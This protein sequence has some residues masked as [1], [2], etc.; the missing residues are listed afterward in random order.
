MIYKRSLKQ[1]ISY[2]YDIDKFYFVSGMFCYLTK[3]AS[4]LSVFC[5][6]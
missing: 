3:V 5:F 2:I 1:N 6:V 4:M